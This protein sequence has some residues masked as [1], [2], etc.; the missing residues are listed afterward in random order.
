MDIIT[1]AYDDLK[2]ITHSVADVQVKIKFFKI[3]LN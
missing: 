3:F 2:A 1:T